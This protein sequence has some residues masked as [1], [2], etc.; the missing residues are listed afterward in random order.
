LTEENIMISTIPHVEKIRTDHKAII[1]AVIDALEPPALLP[2]QDEP[3][4]IILNDSARFEATRML[5]GLSAMLAN[6]DDIV[7][8]LFN[9]A[10]AAR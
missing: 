5:L 2:G 3:A 6:N 4:A 10:K 8:T 7:L 9:S 1:R